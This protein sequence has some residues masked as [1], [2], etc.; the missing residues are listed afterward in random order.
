MLLGVPNPGSWQVFLKRPDNIGL[1]IQEA[2]QKYLKEL[3]LFEN[4]K[5]LQY[6]LYMQLFEDRKGGAS[7]GGASFTGQGIDGPIAGATVTA[8]AEGATTTTDSNGFFRFNFIP[9]GD[10][11]ITGGTDA[12]TGVAF[13]G[14]LKAPK[15]STVISPIT[16]AIKEIM[17]LGS[18]EEEATD[19]VFDY[20]REIYEIDIPSNVRERVKKEN[21]LTL[22][23]TN[24]DFLKVVGFTSILEA[25]AEVAGNGP[26]DSNSDSV[27][28][29]KEAFYKRTA[30]IINSNKTRL[31]PGSGHNWQTGHLVYNKDN[32]RKLSM[33]LTGDNVT[34][35]SSTNA[36][37]LR[38]ALDHTLDRIKEV[39]ND[40]NMDP[41]FGTTAIMTQNRLAKREIAD[42]AANFGKG[43]I[44][45]TTLS[46]NAQA[47]VD[48]EADEYSNLGTIFEGKQNQEEPA[49]EKQENLFP[50]AVD[51]VTTTG[52][53]KYAQGE[54]TRS[55]ATTI[56]GQ[57][58]YS[59]T[60]NSE[61]TF[62][63]YDRTSRRWVLDNN[64]KAPYI[65][66]ANR[67]QSYPVTGNY[68]KNRETIII[69][70]PDV[71]QDQPS[72]G[73]GGRRTIDSLGRKNP[74]RWETASDPETNRETGVT[75][76]TVN[77]KIF[78][79]SIDGR[80]SLV[81][82]FQ[83]NFTI[84]KN[85][86]SQLYVITLGRRGAELVEG[87]TTST[88]R[89]FNMGVTLTDLRQRIDR[90]GGFTPSFVAASFT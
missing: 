48:K 35:I 8:V 82:Y 76:W 74:L 30:T 16:T 63:W 28:R 86:G 64:L 40:A 13:T 14:T 34:T 77:G 33:Q 2:K 19:A 60:I 68:T 85:L 17:D 4:E 67:K 51:Y 47:S 88:L 69:A 49:A 1:S 59:G 23:E 22:A 7:G 61:A 11:E 5:K 78:P 31:K 73:Q 45:G 44:N 56:N 43:N 25:S 57:P 75:T 10:I 12:V 32:F 3:A 15:G 83:G 20:A 50:A 9:S 27:K 21:F 58:T 41:S 36:D 29:H 39:V 24:N 52:G 70:L 38:Q 72:V 54:L 65:G 55:L 6:D 81:T 84:T 26:G 66:T 62:L 90:I 80:A 18:T 46:T 79:S 89:F 71:Y 37:S 42:N 53:N 87:E